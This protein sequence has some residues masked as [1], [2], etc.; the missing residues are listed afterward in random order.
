MYTYTCIY[1]HRYIHIRPH[2]TIYV[3]SYYY[4][5][6]WM[7]RR[8]RLRRTEKVLYRL[9]LLKR[10]MLQS[11]SYMYVC[12]YVYIYHT[13][14]LDGEKVSTMEYWK[15]DML[16]GSTGVNHIPP[17]GIDVLYSRKYCKRAYTTHISP[18]GGG[19]CVHVCISIF[20]WVYLHF[21]VNHTHL[22]ECVCVIHTITHTHTHTHTYKVDMR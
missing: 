8:C 6:G 16:Q 3:S 12:M 19:S 10:D 15:K 1:I 11:S 9:W 17:V 2:A 20:M 13:H 4:I 22:R 18:V 14:R 7:A 5:S 21:C